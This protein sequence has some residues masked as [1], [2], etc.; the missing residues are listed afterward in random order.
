M[1]YGIRE[2]KP[3]VIRIHARRIIMEND[4]LVNI[5]FGDNG[6]GFSEEKLTELNQGIEDIQSQAHIGLA[7]TIRRFIIVCG[8]E[9]AYAFTNRGG[10]Q[11]DLFIPIMNK[12][13]ENTDE[14][15]D[16]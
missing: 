9:F 3:L 6:Y 1:K 12:E 16:S 2:S 10:A 5:T 4:Q 8:D 7:N 13:K 11:I 14:T 15:A